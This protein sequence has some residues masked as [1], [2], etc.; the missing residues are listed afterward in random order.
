[1]PVLVTSRFDED[2]IK[3]KRASLETPFF[4]YMSMGNFSDAQGHL[5]LA[6]IRTPPRFYACPR[7]LEV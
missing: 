5:T 6:E 1:M 3:N 4:H 7:Y 2:P